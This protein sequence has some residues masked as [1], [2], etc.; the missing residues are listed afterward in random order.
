M[1]RWQLVPYLLGAMMP[2]I[3]LIAAAYSPSRQSSMIC[4]LGGRRRQMEA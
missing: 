3:S 2:V 1:Q 4:A